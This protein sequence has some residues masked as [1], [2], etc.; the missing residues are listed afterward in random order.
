M[1]NFLP[2]L[3]VLSLPAA[4]VARPV[5]VHNDCS[6]QSSE[7]VSFRGPP[8]HINPE[9]GFQC[10]GSFGT[11]IRGRLMQCVVCGGIYDGGGL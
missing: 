7:I 1:K 5:H 3:L 11:V 10:M 2:L 4:L 6:N 8:P 9:T